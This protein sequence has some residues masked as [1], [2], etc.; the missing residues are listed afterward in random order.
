M[1]KRNVLRELK[2]LANKK[3]AEV[4]KRFFKTGPGEYG[5][6][7]VFLGLTVPQLRKLARDCHDLTEEEILELLYSDYHEARLLGLIIWVNA[8]P[9]ATEAEK[10]RIYRLYLKHRARI[11]NWDL[12]DTSAPQIVGCHLLKRPR[13]PLYEL[14]RAKPMWDRRIAILSTFSFIRANDFD[15]TIRLAESYLSSPEDLMHKAT[16]WMLREVGKRDDARLREFLD[17]HHQTMPRTMLRYAIEKFSPKD[18]AHYL[19]KG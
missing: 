4:S 16:G 2:A 6:G 8:Y 15:D 12:V 11:N 3:R 10:E 17:E 7:D 14:A 13:G 1:P 9:R 19:K 18:R 5:E